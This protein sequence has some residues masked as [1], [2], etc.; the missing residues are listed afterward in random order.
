M[1]TLG[2]IE[3]IRDHCVSKNEY[4]SCDTLLYC[5]YNSI[6]DSDIDKMNEIIIH[7]INILDYYLLNYQI[8]V[9]VVYGEH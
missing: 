5:I 6:Y 9:W 1:W 8:V 2:D 3:D 4:D 7:N